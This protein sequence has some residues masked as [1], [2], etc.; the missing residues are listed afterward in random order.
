MMYFLIK[1]LVLFVLCI[2]VLD[3]KKYRVTLTSEERKELESLLKRGWVS[4]LK[5]RHAR[6][7]LKAD[8]VRSGATDEQIS[9]SSWGRYSYG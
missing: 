7:L 2:V 6:I 9:P 3:A 1:V 8:E 4:A 5:Q